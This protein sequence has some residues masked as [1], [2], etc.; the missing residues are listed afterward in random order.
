MSAWEYWDKAEALMAEY[1]FLSAGELADELVDAGYILTANRDAVAEEIA[2]HDAVYCRED[3]DADCKCGK[4][5]EDDEYE[6]PDHM[7]DVLDQW[8]TE[9]GGSNP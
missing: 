1:R 3:Y 4:W 2:K 7:G 6:W 8:I 5:L 9:A